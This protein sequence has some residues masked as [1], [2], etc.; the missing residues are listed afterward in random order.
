MSFWIS[1][2]LEASELLRMPCTSEK[3]LED[4]SSAWLCD[5][6]NR[7]L[8]ICVDRKEPANRKASRDRE[9]A[10]TTAE[11]CREVRQRWRRA[12]QSA[13]T[14]PRTRRSGRVR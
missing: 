2:W 14:T 11:N 13:G 10:T 9:V 12:R 7:L 6:R 4:S 1:A 3:P 5:S 8:A